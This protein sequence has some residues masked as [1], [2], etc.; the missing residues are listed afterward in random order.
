MIL[1]K[2]EMHAHVYYVCM[3]NDM[4]QYIYMIHD[5]LILQCYHIKRFTVTVQWTSMI[6]QHRL[7]L[8]GEIH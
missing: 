6:G 2:A 1:A 3:C 4:L 7:F 5:Y 8:H